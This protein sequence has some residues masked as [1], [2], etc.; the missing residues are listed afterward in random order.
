MDVL[1][2]FGDDFCV[3]VGLELVSFLHQEHLDVFVVGY[4]A[5]VD[6]N[7]LVSVVRSL[8]MTIYLVGDSMGCPSCM[9]DTWTVTT[10]SSESLDSN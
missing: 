7:K 8:R 4:D 6:D 9:G 5:V 3:R 1:Y 2:Q 10:F